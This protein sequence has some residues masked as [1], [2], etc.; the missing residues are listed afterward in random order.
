MQQGDL[1]YE[2]HPSP[3]GQLSTHSLSNDIEKLPL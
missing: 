2:F 1:L 3:K